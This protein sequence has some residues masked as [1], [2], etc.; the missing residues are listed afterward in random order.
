MILHDANKKRQPSITIGD[1]DDV[2]LG[3]SAVFETQSLKESQQK[4]RTRSQTN[5]L[6]SVAFRPHLSMGLALSKSAN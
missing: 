4:P 1:L 5:P 2:T 3:S 6:R